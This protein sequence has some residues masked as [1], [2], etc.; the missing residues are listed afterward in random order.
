[1]QHKYSPF[2]GI[3]GLSPDDESAWPLIVS[4]LYDQ[5][6]IPAKIFSFLPLPLGTDEPGS[7]GKNRIA[8]LTFGGF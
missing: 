1:M 2:Q 4:Y 6:K 8:R 7:N 5:E 3:L